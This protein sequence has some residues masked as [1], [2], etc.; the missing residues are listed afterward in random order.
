MRRYF[1]WLRGILL[2]IYLGG[3]FFV[4]IGVLG[5]LTFAGP[6]YI[7]SWRSFAHA[8]LVAATW[9]ITFPLQLKMPFGPRR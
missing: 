9:P 6:P 7:G 5:G 4:F 8:G 3:A 1:Q 2:A